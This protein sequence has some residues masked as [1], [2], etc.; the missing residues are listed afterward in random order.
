MKDKIKIEKEIKQTLN[1][2]LVKKTIIDNK[3]DIEFITKIAFLYIDNSDNTI[4]KTE[5]LVIMDKLINESEFSDLIETH[6]LCDR[7]I[8]DVAKS[9]K[10]INDLGFKMIIDIYN[11]NPL[12]LDY[13][14]KKFVEDMINDQ[15]I[16][17]EGF[18]NNVSIADDKIINHIL[19]KTIEIYDINLAKYIKDKT[20]LLNDIRSKIIELINKMPKFDDNELYYIIEAV[21]EYYK[22]NCEDSI[23]TETDLIYYVAKKFGQDQKLYELEGFSKNDFEIDDNYIRFNEECDYKEKEHV[24]NVDKI[25]QKFLKKTDNK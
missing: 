3:E 6:Y 17:L 12:I 19:L 2:N 16:N 4:N 24:K 25:F 7:V 18:I 23:F 8:I 5:L 20:Y 21:H 15:E 10:I 22:N 1:Y 11:N 13:Y 14:A 9:K